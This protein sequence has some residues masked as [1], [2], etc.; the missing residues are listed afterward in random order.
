MAGS[1]AKGAGS[2][3]LDMVKAAAASDAID[4][5]M[6]RTLGAGS[7]KTLAAFEDIARSSKFD[8]DELKRAAQPLIAAGLRG[9]DLILAVK[10]ALDVEATGAAS[11]DEAMGAL[12]KIKLSGEINDKTLRALGLS[13]KTVF[14]DMAKRLGVSARQAESMAKSG[15]VE[16][17]GLIR[18]M[19]NVVALQS[20]ALGAGAAKAGETLDARLKKLT[21]LPRKFFESFK[22]TATFEKLNAFIG[23]MLAQFDPAGPGGKK[24][25]AFVEKLVSVMGTLVPVIA[26]LVGIWAIYKAAVVGVT[27]VTALFNGALLANPAVLATIAIVSLGVALV[28]L[29]THWDLVTAHLLAFWVSVKEVFSGIGEFFGQVYT[30]FK[31]FGGLLIQGLIDGVVGMASTAVDAVKGVG[32][33]IIGG[34][35][36]VLGIASPSKAFAKIGMFSAEGFAQGIEKGAGG[37]QGAAGGMVNPPSAVGSRGGGGGINFALTINVDGGGMGHAGAQSVAERLR[38]IVPGMLQDAFEKL[39]IEAGGV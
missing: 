16:A 24:V 11:L 14:E 7:A 39:A 36:S 22:D 37:A 13:S 19:A 25:L 1:L 15:R 35:K 4:K 34:M 29:A 12:T 5:T 26:S 33:D 23:R 28:A 27:F 18:E 31:E 21:D 17:V 2:M 8:D 20:G 9:Q 6:T 3:A 10:T 38:E 30:D 32:S